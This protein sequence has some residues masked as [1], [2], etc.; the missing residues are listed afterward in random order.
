MS[1]LDIAVL[2]LFFLQILVTWWRQSE[3]AL[4]VSLA[5]T[6]SAVCFYLVLRLLYRR[7]MLV[8]QIVVRG[9]TVYAMLMA[10]VDGYAQVHNVRR[11]VQLF[12]SAKIADIHAAMPLVGAGTKNDNLAL[13]LL[14]SSFALSCAVARGRFNVSWRAVGYAASAVLY[15][16]FIFSFSRA[17]YIAG[18]VLLFAA[19]CLLIIAYRANGIAMATRLGLVVIAPSIIAIVVCGVGNAT[20]LTLIGNQSITQRRST[21]GRIR[22]WK[23]ALDPISRYP[24]FGAGGGSD[25]AVALKRLPQMN[26]AFVIGEYNIFINTTVNYGIVGLLL[27][28]F[29]V[30]TL[31]VRLARI[32]RKDPRRAAVSSSILM[33][34][35]VALITRDMFYSSIGTHPLTTIVFWLAMGVIANATDVSVRKPSAHRSFVWTRVACGGV[36]AVVAAMVLPEIRIDKAERIYKLGAAELRRG[37]PDQAVNDFKRA[38][39]LV[40]D[41]PILAAAEGL[42]EVRSTVGERLPVDRPAIIQSSRDGLEEAAKDYS[43]AISLSRNDGEFWAGLASVESYLGND[44][45]ARRLYGNAIELDPGDFIACF[46]LGM[47]EE[48]DGRKDQAV[49][50][51]ANAV[52]LAPRVLGSTFFV[53]LKS[54]DRGIFERVLRSARAIVAAQGNSPIDEAKLG[55]I[56]DISG[57]RSTARRE[58][59]DALQKMPELSA[60]WSNLGLLNYSD[61]A[62]DEARL[63]FKRALLLDETDREANNMLAKIELSE[64][65]LDEAQRLFARALTTPEVS[66]HVGRVMLVYHTAAPGPD[67]SVPSM[68]ASYISSGIQPLDTCGDWITKVSLLQDLSVDAKGR[69]EQQEKFCASE[70]N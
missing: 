17:I 68:F 5:P 25:G 43:A 50:A 26:G 22:I 31:L 40:P 2:L 9:L 10:I 30:G 67:D 59:E 60:G 56:D 19:S 4:V 39:K 36:I 38:R 47:L 12:G 69:I 13:L 29:I 33:A 42:A 44:D 3:Y 58:Y 66:T 48:K 64:G 46:G 51:Y 28:S 65:N 8:T 7:R 53:D 45:D 27:F 52:A 20:T 15:V 35:V 24:L 49:I 11:A 61:G 57:D 54:R 70:N 37:N 14:L 6:A 1:R 32:L 41:Q 34:G 55:R 62:I 63:D 16:I 21:D 18:S 23:A